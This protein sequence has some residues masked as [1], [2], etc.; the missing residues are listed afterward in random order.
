[1]V[2]TVAGWYCNV[3]FETLV[4][5]L[6]LSRNKGYDDADVP[7]H[8]SIMTHDIFWPYDITIH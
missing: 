5:V 3:S 6:C 7:H 2:V 1:M 4:L 8:E